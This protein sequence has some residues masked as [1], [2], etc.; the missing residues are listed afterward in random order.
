MV[1]NVIEEDSYQPFE[2]ATWNRWF[3]SWTDRIIKP[4]DLADVRGMKL[5]MV[6]LIHMMMDVWEMC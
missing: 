2:I 4:P 1:R 5:L 3:D 6:T